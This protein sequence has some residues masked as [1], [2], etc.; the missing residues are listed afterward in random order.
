MIGFVFSPFFSSLP[1]LLS[2]CIQDYET[3]LWALL[4]LLLLFTLVVY[5]E[6]GGG[7]PKYI[8][9]QQPCV[10]SFIIRK[11]NNNKKWRHEYEQH[12]QMN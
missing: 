8:S 12:C 5:G 7:T 11:Q 1:L 6:G 9:A 4:F 3:L 2:P 10:S